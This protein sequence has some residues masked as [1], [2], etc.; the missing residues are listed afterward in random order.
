MGR[1]QPVLA[2]H[3]AA[4]E[5]IWSEVYGPDYP[6]G[7][8]LFGFTTVSDLQLLEQWLAG[9]RRIVDLGCGRGGGGGLIADRNA[10]LLVGV[11]LVAEAIEAARARW[12][13]QF[14]TCA[15]M[16]ET[17]LEGGLFDGVLSID[18]SWMVSA[19]RFYGEARRLLQPGGLLCVATWERREAPESAA[20]ERNGFTLE[21]WH[22]PPNWRER[23]RAVYELILSRR[24]QLAAQIGAAAA[25]VLER[26]ALE[27]GPALDDWRRIVVRARR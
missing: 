24:A 14:F 11:D 17:G 2:Q 7:L 6:Q 1:Y 8:E 13:H 16:T 15:D 21:A 23:Q 18:A 12:P 27:F 22:E 10:S 9:C 3:S 5:A 25:G 4:L 20:L 26:E 19:D